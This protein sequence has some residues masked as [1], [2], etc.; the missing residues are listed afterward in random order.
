MSPV[1]IDG[2]A[3]GTMP[4]AL[5]RAGHARGVLI[6]FAHGAG[7]GHR[8]PFMRR[9][10]ALLAERGFDV[11]TFDFPYMAAGRKLADKAPVLEA[12]FHAAVA[13]GLAATGAREV[14]VAGK[15][16]GGRMATHLAAAPDAWRAPAPLTAAVAF[17]YP[18]RPPGPRG[19]DRVSHL[20]RLAV[21]TLIVQGTRDTFGGPDAVAA[22]VG[23]VPH[24]TVLPV[25]T[26]DHS[27]K[28]RASLGRAQ[29]DVES[30]IAGRVAAWFD[31][32]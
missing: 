2:A 1:V 29:E 11:L 7:A 4:G 24:L 8:S 15:S 3:L 22:D 6:V 13:A 28:V 14:I 18:L 20:R 5:V 27:L 19:G 32:L 23:P 25:E 10:A 12:A 16:M 30:D 31:G 9:Y 17:G 21:P 26:G